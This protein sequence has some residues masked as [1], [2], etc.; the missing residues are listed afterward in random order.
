MAH[1]AAICS[2]PAGAIGTA[3][4]S[5]WSAGASRSLFGDLAVLVFLVAQL[6]DGTLTYVGVL[7]FGLASEGNPILVALMEA[8]GYGT[9][10]I[11]AKVVA[12]LLGIGLHLARVH[13]AVALLAGFYMAAAVL[14]WT[15]ILL[16]RT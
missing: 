10:L 14:P 11:A 7:T 3:F 2:E 16:L 8:F 13:L 1:Q 4:P 12:A 9:A 5:V 15:A 6:L